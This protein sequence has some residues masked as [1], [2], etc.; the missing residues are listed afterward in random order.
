MVRRNVVGAHYGIKDWIIQR[1]TAVIM[2]LYSALLL[3]LLLIGSPHDFASWRAV[4]ANI[5]MQCATFAFMLAL[6]WHAWI[7]VRDIWMDYIKSTW[8]R[9]S[10]HVTTAS[11]LITYAGWSAK[12]VWGLE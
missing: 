11:L 10:L 12:I 1:A 9:V 7:G 4:F 8:L 3:L 6:C 5:F 2:A